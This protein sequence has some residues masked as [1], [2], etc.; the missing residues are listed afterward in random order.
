MNE[1]SVEQARQHLGELVRAANRGEV[2]VVTY[3]GI[4]A[5]AIVPLALIQDQPEV[6]KS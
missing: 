4:P 6:S 3:A 5:A 2:T 1:Q